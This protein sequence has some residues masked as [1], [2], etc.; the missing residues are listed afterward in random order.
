MGAV[1]TCSLGFGFAA[2]PSAA[3][4]AAAAGMCGR[5][6]MGGSRCSAALPVG[7]RLMRTASSPSLISISAM[8]DSSSSSISF[9]ILRMS[10]REMP[11]KDRIRAVP[12]SGE[13]LRGGAHRRLVAI[14]AET[15]D[16]A[17]R[18]VGEVG[19]AAERLARL[20]VGKMYLD[21]RHPDRQHRIAQRDARVGE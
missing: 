19:M 18:D 17:D 10:M 7:M 12:L 8:P 13:P 2:A 16:H 4:A 5:C 1:M 15:G 6:A 3:A 9:L 21:E 14:G 20:G 11:P